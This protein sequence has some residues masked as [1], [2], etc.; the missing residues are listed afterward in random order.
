MPDK[1]AWKASLIAPYI[2]PGRGEE[3]FAPLETIPN[4]VILCVEGRITAIGASIPIPGDYEVID[5]G[6]SI[7]CPPLVNAH[8]HLQLSW[9]NKRTLWGKG[10]TAWLKSML[11]QLF[12]VIRTGFGLRQKRAMLAATESLA[13]SG[14]GAIGDVGGSIPG[15]IE[16]SFE[17]DAQCLRFCEWFGFGP[18]TASPWPSRCRFYL[19]NHPRDTQNCSPSAH[20]LYSTSESC[21]CKAHDWCRQTGRVFTFHLAESPEETEMLVSGTGPLAEL[22][23]D[24]VLPPDWKPSGATPFRTAMG[25]N[26][27]D[28][29]TLAVHGAQLERDE[30]KDFA[31]TGAALCLCPRS[32]KNLSVGVAPV[33]SLIA[34]GALLCLGT[35]GLTSCEDLDIRNEARFLQSRFDLPLAAILRMAIPNGRVALGME[36][37]ALQPGSRAFFSIWPLGE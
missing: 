11:L 18:E 31:A 16:T 36:V 4:G 15:A 30:V 23:R 21:L 37:E 10:F 26:L 13:A 6:D 2:A 24:I 14:T 19:E 25:Y 5:C 32:N 8:T 20:A 7:I 28:E 29:K 22:Y 9:L 34:A 33:E 3:L 12:P 1:K 17:S 35:D 27:L